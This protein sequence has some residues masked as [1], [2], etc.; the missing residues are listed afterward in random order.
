MHAL[1]LYTI[2]MVLF[3]GL[4]GLCYALMGFQLGRKGRP[5]QYLSLSFD[6]RVRIGIAREVFESYRQL[7]RDEGKAA[8]LPALVWVSVAFAILFLA[9]YVIALLT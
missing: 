3:A 9:L 7:K 5:A 4:A 8:L 2:G 1:V 6:S